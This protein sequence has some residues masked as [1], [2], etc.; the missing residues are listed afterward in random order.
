[1]MLLMDTFQP[2][3]I[4][5]GTEGATLCD[6]DPSTYLKKLHKTLQEVHQLAQEHLHTGLCY[7]KK[8]YDLKLQ[9]SHFE[10]GDPV[11]WLNA[12]S[13]KGECKKLKPIWI[14]PLVITEVISPVLYHVKDHHCEFILHHDHLK[15]CQD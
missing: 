2:V 11:Y 4:L 5:M 6:E 9:E 7:Q 13:K 1:M 12:V 15:L 8:T 14:G 3:D 10:V